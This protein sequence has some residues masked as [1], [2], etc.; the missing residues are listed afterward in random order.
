MNLFT[1]N[2]KNSFYLYSQ[3]A[4]GSSITSEH[5][6]DGCGN[7]VRYLEHVQARV[8]FQSDKRGALEIFLTSPSGLKSQLLTRR[9]RDTDNNEIDWFF[10]TVH[11][12]GENPSG[13]WRLRVQT[14][15]PELGII[16]CIFL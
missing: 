8:M 16:S 6:S 1:Y 11:H 13:K 5:L 12:W 15:E 2:V 14:K 3:S 4:N 7:G 9:P 10:M